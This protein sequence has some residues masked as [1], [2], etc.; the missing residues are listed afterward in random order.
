ML[1]IIMNNFYELFE[2]Q[3]SA[4]TKQI[5]NAYENK[6]TKYNNIQKL[7]EQQIYEIKMLK[8]GLHVLTN[9]E[10]RK[11]YDNNHSGLNNSKN[12]HNNEPSPINNDND[13]ATLDHVF[14]VDNSWMKQLQDKHNVDKKN[15]FDTNIGNRVFSLT[16]MNKRPGYSSEFEAN[17]RKPHQGREDKTNQLINKN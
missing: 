2:I 15:N 16:E 6:I 8:I 1:T 17:L 9:Q 13:D 12:K 14:N 10:L 3:K 11:K 7:S 4:T 5:I